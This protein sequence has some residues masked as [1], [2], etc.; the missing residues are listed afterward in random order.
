MEEDINLMFKVRH[1]NNLEEMI[2]TQNE[3]AGFL[4]QKNKFE[5]AM[6]ELKSQ[7]KDIFNKKVKQ[8]FMPTIIGNF[9]RVDCN[10]NR[11]KDF[12]KEK[13]EQL[14]NSIKGI[15]EQ[16]RHRQEVVNENVNRAIKWFYEYLD[17][18]GLPIPEYKKKE[19]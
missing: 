1:M 13:E 18:Q 11:W 6:K 5:N 14:E 10:D 19:A 3:L 4:Q 8:I 16:I 15:E 17:M 12:F 9:V 2:K 7:K